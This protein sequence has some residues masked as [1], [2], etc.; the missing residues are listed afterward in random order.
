MDRN[1]FF[2]LISCISSLIL[3][4]LLYTQ[5]KKINPTL[6]ISLQIST[7]IILLISLI[8]FL[9]KSN[10]ESETKTT[11][12]YFLEQFQ[13]HMDANNNN[14]IIDLFSEA[15][16]D[17]SFFQSDI[18]ENFYIL[19]KLNLQKKYNP[20]E[21]DDEDLYENWINF[22]AMIDILFW[23]SKYWM[24]R[25]EDIFDTVT[26]ILLRKVNLNLLIDQFYKL[27]Y[28]IRPELLEII[29][30]INTEQKIIK[31]DILSFFTIINDQ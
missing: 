5:S 20:K 12:R 31:T 11:E 30:R 4:G 14:M 26:K 17:F 29:R 1:K 2:A 13:Q 25:N 22:H 8:I 19:R 28:K 27:P 3:F 16:A 24:S 21:I 15:F 7:A 9:K 10:E 6:W 18:L 23:S